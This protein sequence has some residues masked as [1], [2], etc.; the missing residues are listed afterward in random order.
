MLE[1]AWTILLTIL[2]WI[3]IAVGGLILLI[4]AFV[5]LYLPIAAITT[6]IRRTGQHSHY[7][8]KHL[9]TAE[10]DH[11][12]ELDRQAHARSRGNRP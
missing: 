5:I 12:A 6:A 8:Y 4:F 7:R 1:T 10:L 3:G 9:T 11:L 2:T